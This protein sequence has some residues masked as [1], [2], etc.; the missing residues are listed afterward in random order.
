MVMG[1]INGL[2]VELIQGAGNRI[3]W[4]DMEHIHFQVENSMKD[5]IKMMLK[6][7]MVHLNGQME[8]H[9]LDG[10]LKEN[11]TVKVST[12]ILKDLDAKESGNMVLEKCGL[13]DTDH[14]SL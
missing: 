7:D 1:L 8:E 10:G 5:N 3:K 4:M 14:S 2:M 9:I 11:N 13:H 6:M 12:Q